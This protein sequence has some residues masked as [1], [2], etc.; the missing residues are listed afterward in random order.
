MTKTIS[1]SLESFV[2]N[3]LDY[4]GMFPPARLDLAEAFYNY[5][6]YKNGKYNWIVSKF[7]C[8]ARK[9]TEL[10]NLIETKYKDEADISISVLGS[11]GSDEDDFRSNFET[12]LKLW[13]GFNIK[14]GVKV[15]TNFYETRLPDDLI[16][17]QNYKETSRFIDLFTSEIIDNIKQPVY[18][19]T[20]CLMGEDWKKDIRSLVNAIELHN[21]KSNNCGFKLRTGGIEPFSF[22]SPGQIALSIRECLDRKTTL[23]FTAGLHH[24]IRHY[25][26]N[27]RTMMH[28]FINVFASGILAM[29]HN[30]SDRNI[31]EILDDENRDNFIFS[32][33]GFS[34]KDW[35]AGIKDIEFA[36]KN[37]VTS[38]GSCSIDEPVDD[39]KSLNL[40]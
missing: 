32:E 6:K 33:T 38:Y 23:K 5:V 1:N 15:K 36:R 18:F 20:E 11:C 13:K 2:K 25:D 24:P 29:R 12:D 39:L 30:I 40:L 7:I 3:I 14:C 37:L 34:W 10:G 17:K 31:R 27:I 22:P 9:L 8:P 16:L 19:F 28:G 26:S 35:T 21:E 4:A